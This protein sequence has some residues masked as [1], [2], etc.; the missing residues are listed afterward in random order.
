MHQSQI[1]YLKDE[2]RESE[3]QEGQEVDGIVFE[4]TK[5]GAR[6]AINGKYKG[7]IF[8][9]EIARPLQIDQQLRFYIKAIREDGKIDLALKPKGYLGY[10]QSSTEQV[11]TLLRTAPYGEMPFNDKSDPDD[12]RKVFKMSKKVFKESIG[13]LYK[14]RLIEISHR[15]IKL[16]NKPR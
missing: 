12:I 7:M 5:L 8:Q 6:I 14:Q 3:L 13:K 2:V 15:G 1:K 4:F 16:V 10:I 9:D 11:L